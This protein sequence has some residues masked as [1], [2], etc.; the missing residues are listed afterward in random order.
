MTGGARRYGRRNL[1]ASLAVLPLLLMS[2]GA[3]AS[4]VTDPDA[5]REAAQAVLSQGAFQTEL[6][7]A[8][9]EADDVPAWLLNFL[10]GSWTTWTR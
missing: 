10:E 5:I 9:P 7:E 4:D 1:R 8:D 3:Q 2:F 6:P